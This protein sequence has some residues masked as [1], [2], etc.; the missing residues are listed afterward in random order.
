MKHLYIL[1][2]LIPLSISAQ[3]PQHW[4]GRGKTADQHKDYAG[5]DCSQSLVVTTSITSSSS[6]I[7]APKVTSL[8]N[9]GLCDVRTS[10][11]RDLVVLGDQLVNHNDLKCVFEVY[12]VNIYRNISSEGNIYN[13]RDFT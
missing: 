5:A 9:Y 10:P 8:A 6:E 13:L 3:T 2:L 1:I 7:A 4:F 12:K 11:C